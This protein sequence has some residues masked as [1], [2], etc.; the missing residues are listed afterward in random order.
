MEVSEKTREECVKKKKKRES[1]RRKKKGS[2][3]EDS[4]G[5]EEKC[6]EGEKICSGANQH[7]NHP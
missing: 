7:L 2:R 6:I 1:R 3:G 4:E 5:N